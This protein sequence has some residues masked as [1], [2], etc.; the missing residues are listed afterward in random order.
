LSATPSIKISKS[1]AYRGGTKVWSNRYHFA[2]GTP[3]NG[4]AWGTLANNVAQ[5][6][7]L[8]FERPADSGGYDVAIVEATG[9]DAGSDVPVYTEALSIAAT[10]NFANF[11]VKTGDTAALIKFTTDQRTSKNHPIYLFNYVHGALGEGDV[12]GD[13]LNHA[14]LAALQTYATAW[15]AGF[16]DGTNTYTRA[17]PNGAVALTRIVEEYLTHRDFPR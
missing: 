12:L 13:E 4:T 5:A 10:G 7:K 16:S 15:I 1:F 3:A 6:E 2:G 8:C 9:Y 11:A 17:G 14:Q